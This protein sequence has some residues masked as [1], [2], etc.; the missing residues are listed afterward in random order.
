MSTATQ[1]ILDAW[2]PPFWLSVSVVLV[3]LVYAWMA[4]NSPHSAGLFHRGA[5][6]V[7]FCRRDGGSVACHRFAHRRLSA[8]TL[9]SAR[10]VRAPPADVCCAT[11]GAARCP[12]STHAAR[13]AARI[14]QVFLGPLIALRWL[15]SVGHFLTDPIVAWLTFNSA[16]SSLA[17][18]QGIR[19]RPSRRKH[20]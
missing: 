12:R 15:R 7:N 17:S 13:P 14:R 4:C 20:S 18:A 16:L 8:D 11:A 5:A 9:L 2:S 1:A 6:S 19:L 3:C 10:M